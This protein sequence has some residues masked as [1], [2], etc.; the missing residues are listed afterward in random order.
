MTLSNQRHFRQTIRNDTQSSSLEDCP[1]VYFVEIT[2]CE[3]Q[4]AMQVK[5]SVS[6]RS[7]ALV[8]DD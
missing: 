5:V 3:Y 2:I 8:E 7:V 1:G 4:L 6:F